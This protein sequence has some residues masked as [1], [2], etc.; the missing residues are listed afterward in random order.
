MQPVF[1]FL[2]AHGI[3]YRLIEH[4]A[5]FRVGE[6]PEELKGVFPTKNLLVKDMKADQIYLVMM[7]GEKKLDMANL[8]VVL[9]TTKSKLRFLKYDEVEPAVGVLPGSVSVLNL[10]NTQV[11]GIKVV[12]DTALHTQKEI[13]SHPNVNTATVL[14]APAD[15]LRVLEALGKEVIEAAV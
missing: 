15:T 10:L 8:A 3:P 4:P 12:F 11:K 7:E 1:D 13:G 9:S 2:N 6:E 5:V 14:M